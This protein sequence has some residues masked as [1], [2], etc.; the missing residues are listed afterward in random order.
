M[1]LRL[2]LLLLILIL[3]RVHSAHANISNYNSILIG[4]QAAGMGGA[5]T[6]MTEDASALPWYNPAGLAKLRGKSFSAAVGIY[7]K[8]DTRFQDDGDLTKASLRVNQGFFRALPSST[9]S[10]VRPKE[11]PWLENWTLALS[12]LVPE[13]ETFK[14]DVFGEGQSVST[15]N[16]TTESIWVG[17]AAS[18]MVKADESMGIT[19]YYTARSVSKSVS[20]RTYIDPTRSQIFTEER[21][22]TQNGVVAILGWHKDLSPKWKLGISQRLP[23]LHVAG[24][25]EVYQAMISDGALLEPVYERRLDTKTRIP[26]KTSVGVAYVDPGRSRWA[27]DVNYY[28]GLSY[29]DL[30]SY[31]FAERIE[32]KPTVNVSLGYERSWTRF[33][34]SRTGFFSNYSSHPD[35]DPTLVKGQGDHVDQA[36]FSANLA[37][38][39]G[40]IEYTF[41]GYYTGGRGRSVQRVQQEYVVLPKVQNIFTMLV[42]TSYYF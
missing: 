27:L 23:S 22:I 31:D 25:A 13:Y 40:R 6:A 19:I 35:P 5:A 28:Q 3:A 30:E 33:L 20:D 24:S 39:S 15:L 17:I 1:T 2:C 29:G 36:G 7:K 37:F 8:F 26:A 9:G 21:N 16:L 11:I 10:I 38:R 42:G 32:H 18:K 4:D 14:G 41:G 12:I 34:K